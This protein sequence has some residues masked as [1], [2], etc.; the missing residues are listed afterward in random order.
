[1]FR[2]LSAHMF[3]VICG[4]K[5]MGAKKDWSLGVSADTVFGLEIEF[6]YL[7]FSSSF[8]F[9][10]SPCQIFALF[11]AY[12]AENFTAHRLFFSGE[13]MGRVILNM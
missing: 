11:K 5:K 13:K 8:L 1:M 10:M 12:P 2:F 3:C 6:T 9:S 4:K 7:T